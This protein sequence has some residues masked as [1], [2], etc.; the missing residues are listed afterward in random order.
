MSNNEPAR[1]LESEG[2]SSSPALVAE[3]ITSAYAS[4][5]ESVP[6]VFSVGIP[7]ISFPIFQPIV[8]APHYPSRLPDSR[9]IQDLESLT[10]IKKKKN[11]QRN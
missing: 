1:P 10:F 4:P 9:L 11:K 6:F 5:K 7:F 2:S 8:E 3:Y